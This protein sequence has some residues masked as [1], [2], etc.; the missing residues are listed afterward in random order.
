MLLTAATYAH[1]PWA[2]GLQLAGWAIAR[3]FGASHRAG[4]WLGAFAGA[5]MCVTRE[6]TQREYQ[7]IEAYGGGLRRNMPDLAGFRVWEWTAHSL[8]ETAAGI[9]AVAVAATI[10]GRASRRP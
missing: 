3:R 10:V 1:V 8:A 2:L 5:V 7:W 4:A 9:A 6:V